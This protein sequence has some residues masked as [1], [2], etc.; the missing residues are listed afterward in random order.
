MKY[1]KGGSDDAEIANAN[2]NANANTT[3]TSEA[4]NTGLEDKQPT[5]W[6]NITSY[7]S[8]S[9]DETPDE[10]NATIT[11]GGKRKKKTGRNKPKKNNKK[12]TR[13]PRSKK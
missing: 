9:K 7:F 8:A 2:A 13:R 1:Q 11:T 4:V 6:K 3:I 5:W 10:S 12:Y